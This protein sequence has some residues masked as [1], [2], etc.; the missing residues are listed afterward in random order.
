MQDYV[1]WFAAACVLVAAELFTGTFY[2]LMI[3]IG[4]TAGG[5]TALLGSELPLQLV[6]G[7]AVGIAATVIL[8]RTRWG[9]LQK[10]GDAMHNPDV[11]LDIGQTVNVGE[12]NNGVTRVHYRGAS[13]EAVMETGAEPVTG[14]L[15]IK[16]IRG[17]TLVLASI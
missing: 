2:L 17:S 11:N 8:R 1:I 15:V 3:A 9:K 14:N 16:A 5:L 10:Q 7:A 4:F 6:V 13:W 12:W